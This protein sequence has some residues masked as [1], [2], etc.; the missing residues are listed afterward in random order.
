MY[1]RKDFYWKDKVNTIVQQLVEAGLFVKWQRD[2]Q[3]HGKYEIP[4]A[5]Q[6][7]RLPISHASAALV[8]LIGVGSLMSISTFIVEQFVFWKMK[9]PN[10]LKI[11]M[12]LE[13]FVDG[14]RHYL[15]N[16]PERLQKQNKHSEIIFPYLE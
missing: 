13:Q 4:Y 14:H 16:V 9:Q 3:L 12:Y 11:W 5:A 1:M 15:K 10:K 2:S 6:P 8:F 7:I